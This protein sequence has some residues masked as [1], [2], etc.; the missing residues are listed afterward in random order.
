MAAR[1]GR[2]ASSRRRLRREDCRQRELRPPYVGGYEVSECH[3][4]LRGEEDCGDGGTGELE[5]EFTGS[6]FAFDGVAGID[7][8]AASGQ[9]AAGG[10]DQNIAGGVFEIADEDERVGGGN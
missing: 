2:S 9:V 4:L 1:S 7:L 8:D 6:E 10:A 3:C 5:A